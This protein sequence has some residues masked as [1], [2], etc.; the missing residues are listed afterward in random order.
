[1]E[2]IRTSQLVYKYN[3]ERWHI[4]QILVRICKR[5]S[6]SELAFS[7]RIIKDFILEGFLSFAKLWLLLS[8]HNFH[9]QIKFCMQ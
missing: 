6:E 3:A 7:S 5:T 2:R 9:V 1:M 4:R 8:Y